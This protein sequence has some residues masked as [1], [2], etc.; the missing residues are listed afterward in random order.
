ML[1]ELRK[2][3]G[4]KGLTTAC[5]NFPIDNYMCYDTENVLTGGKGL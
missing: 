4:K 1:S 3:I 2:A 5:W